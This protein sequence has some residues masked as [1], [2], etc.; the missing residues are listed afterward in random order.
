[1]RRD[2]DAPAGATKD[3]WITTDTKARLFAD[4]R[5]PALDINVDTSDGVVTL[6]GNVSSKNARIAAAADAHEVRG[7]TRVV[8]DLQ[9]VPS[10]KRDKVK[11]RDEDLKA[12]VTQA[13]ARREGLA[14]IAVDVRNGMVRFTGTVEHEPQRLEAAIVARSTPGVRAVEDDLRK[15]PP[16][17]ER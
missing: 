2:R 1:M 17:R 15:S 4:S 6:F 10:A 16:A 9:V 5:T 8:N 12:T 13:L 7:V 3:M 11:V 14:D